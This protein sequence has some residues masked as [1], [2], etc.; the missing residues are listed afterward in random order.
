M[1]G[2][3]FSTSQSK[4]PT[5]RDEPQ[6]V[7]DDEGIV[8]ATICFTP[9]PSPR[10]SPRTTPAS[11]MMNSV[12]TEEYIGSIGAL[13]NDGK[14]KPSLDDGS[15]NE[16]ELLDGIDSK[17]GSIAVED[18][19]LEE[20]VVGDLFSDTAKAMK[21]DADLGLK[22]L[23]DSPP[24]S[25][26][27]LSNEE[28]EKPTETPL[29]NA[30]SLRY[31][32]DAANFSIMTKRMLS[33]MA[34]LGKEDAASVED[35]LGAPSSPKVD[36]TPI[37]TLKSLKAF[38]ENRILGK[39]A[40]ETDDI[41]KVANENPSD[42]SDHQSISNSIASSRASQRIQSKPSLLSSISVVLW[43]WVQSLALVCAFSAKK[44]IE[45]ICSALAR[46]IIS[47]AARPASGTLDKSV[48]EIDFGEVAGSTRLNLNTLFL[49][50]PNGTELDPTSNEA[51]HTA[52]EATDTQSSSDVDWKVI[53]AR[54]I[55]LT[56]FVV[57]LLVRVFGTTSTLDDVSADHVCLTTNTT[58]FESVPV[59]E[60]NLAP[61]DTTHIRTFQRSSSLRMISFFT[62]IAIAFIC[63]YVYE[64]D[65]IKKLSIKKEAD[66]LTGIWTAREHEQFIKGFDMHGSNWKLVAPFI[67]SR[68]YEQVKAH[69][70]HWKKIGSPDTMKRSKKI[71]VE[72]SPKPIAIASAALAQLTPKVS[73]V[74]SPL[75][76]K[77]P[78]PKSREE[79]LASARDY[80]R[81]LNKAQSSMKERKTKKRSSRHSL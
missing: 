77:E 17:E 43:L 25:V 24:S 75:I 61:T 53:A 14:E 46:N 52:K 6:L 11:L 63:A 47:T 41:N 36:A 37:S 38:W 19:D 42:E 58:S 18:L 72:T 20:E 28:A 35:D 70:I 74:A 16:F 49:D 12:E 66:H 23:L 56:V 22:E 39:A 8:G 44:I 62:S 27:S 15:A 2:H 79:Q 51:D 78:S 29:L 1:E 59:W 50:E 3:F 9:Q 13:T 60:I 5:K 48:D 26:P 80:A 33:H 71:V 30:E 45:Q 54:V 21:N 81:T 73:N 64:P 68:N 76:K 69:G 57:H 55:A 4:S 34:K 31:S 67:P 65:L 40:E 7:A 10:G 32:D